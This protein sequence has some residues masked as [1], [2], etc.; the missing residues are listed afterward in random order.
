METELDAKYV[1][2]LVRAALAEDRAGDDVTTAALVP[3]DQAGRAELIAKEQ[4]VLAGLAFAAAAFAAVDPKLRWSEEAADGDRVSPGQVVA[5]V[6]GS[7]ASILRG[8][9]V[10]LNFVCHLSG[11]A[12]AA[13]DVVRLLEGTGCRLRDTRKTTPGL[14]AAEKYATRMGGATNH[15][16]DLADG[17]LIKDNHIAALRERDLGVGDAVRLARAANPG[18]RIECEVTSLAEAREAAGAGADEL[19]LDNMTP[20]EVREIVRALGTPRPVLEASGGI[21]AENARAY[22]EAGVDYISMGA[23]THSARALDLSLEVE[24]S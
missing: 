14:R 7:L 12:T 21:T 5:R 16:L 11:V 19:L 13:N 4:G 17:V 1:R 10:A 18:M 24:A 15:R 9:R 23:I 3:P 20:D 8:E 6:E 22:A 2:D